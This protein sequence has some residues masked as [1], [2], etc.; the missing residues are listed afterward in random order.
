MTIEIGQIDN[1]KLFIINPFEMIAH[2]KSASSKP[3]IMSVFE[4]FV[5]LISFNVPAYSVDHSAH[6]IVSPESQPIIDAQSKSLE[7]SR[8][9]L[10]L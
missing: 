6:R 3:A 10:A 8:Y 7:I 9:S 5:R 1:L 4:D 2:R